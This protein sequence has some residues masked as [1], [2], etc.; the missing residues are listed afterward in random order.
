MRVVGIASGTKIR[1]PDDAYFSFFNSPYIGHGRG[2]SID[3]YPVHQS[4]SGDIVSPVT[5]KITRMK[6]MKMGRPKKFPTDDFDFAMGIQP[7]NSDNDIVRIMHC[8]P[9]VQIGDVVET[10][11]P[12]GTT[13]RS[14][15]FNYWTGPHYHVEVMDQDS[16][17]RS[18]KSY[19]F[20]QFFQFSK[21]KGSKQTA[22]IEFEVSEV[23]KD[24][25]KGFPR[26]LEHAT[27]SDLIGLAAKDV[28]NHIV[29]IIDGGLSH[30]KQGGVVGGY[31]IQKTTKV[32]IAG[33]PVGTM[34]SSNR[35]L[36]GPAI[37]SFLDDHKLRG[38]SCFIYPDNYARKG[39]TPLILVPRRYNEFK[40]LIQD[41]DVCQLQIRSKNNTVKAD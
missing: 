2:S 12:I 17:E 10:G 22:R 16:F 36:R 14:R 28:G 41:G 30:Y 26:G 11:D 21:Q 33:I 24:Y 7:D 27:I 29:G 4:W 37:S 23:T 39:A 5:G 20:D 1:A 38:L 3:I 40:G 13:L 35:F 25:V 15:F 6:K 31:A 9:S 34:S 19:T 18:S 32:H 8:T